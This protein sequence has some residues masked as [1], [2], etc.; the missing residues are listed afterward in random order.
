MFTDVKERVTRAL[1]IL[2]MDT[3]DK[4]CDFLATDDGN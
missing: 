2:K 1:K 3:A 4:L